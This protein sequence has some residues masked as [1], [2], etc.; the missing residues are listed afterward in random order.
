MI[1]ANPVPRRRR[2]PVVLV[3]LLVVAGGLV[4]AVWGYGSGVA[5]RAIEG[6]K[7]REAKAGRVYDCA[8]QS[9]GGFPFGLEVHCGGATA[10]LKS[11]QPPLVV[12]AKGM[13][14]TAEL[15]RPTV[16]TTEFNGPLTV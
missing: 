14:V 5:E 4:A 9:I 8:T 10:E 2:W 12:K 16:L 15:W 1:Q 6:W 13:V 3:V 11:N 7:A